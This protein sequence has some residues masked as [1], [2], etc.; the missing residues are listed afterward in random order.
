ML[1]ATAD[2]LQRVDVV[3]T[4]KGPCIAPVAQ[5]FGNEQRE[6]VPEPIVSC[7]KD[8]GRWEPDRRQQTEQLG[9]IIATLH[10]RK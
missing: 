3:P 6:I 4:R 7:K 8:T 5:T 1:P 9:L 2:D 10:L